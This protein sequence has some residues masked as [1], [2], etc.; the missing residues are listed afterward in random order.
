MY[1]FREADVHY[2]CKQGQVNKTISLSN[3]IDWKIHKN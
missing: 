2:K 3:L 1:G